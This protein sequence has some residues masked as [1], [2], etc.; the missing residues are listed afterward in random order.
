M[1]ANTAVLAKIHLALVQEWTQ[2]TYTRP[3]LIKKESFA[4]LEKLIFKFQ[5]IVAGSK[6]RKTST[7]I[8][9]AI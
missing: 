3:R 5:K 1:A 7:A 9:Q 2:Y 4:F 8:F 6:A